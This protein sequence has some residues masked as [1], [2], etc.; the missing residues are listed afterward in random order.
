VLNPSVLDTTI[1]SLLLIKSPSLLP[2]E[3]L[4]E[5]VSMVLSFQSVAEMRYGALIAN[6]GEERR[7]EL[8]EFLS[9]FIVVGYTDELATLWATTM[10]EAR[11]A[12]RRLEA[13][14]AWIAA[15]ARLLNAPLLTHDK[16]FSPAACPSITVHCYAK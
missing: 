12:G 6:W 16:D 13:G 5:E 7:Q 8:E 1:A 2:Y 11:R 3:P 15:T 9:S 14:D 10:H 4:L